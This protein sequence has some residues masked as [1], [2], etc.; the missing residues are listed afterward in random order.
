[1]QL[2]SFSSP[3]PHPRMHVSEDSQEPTNFLIKLRLARSVTC[4]FS[5]H[6]ESQW[7]TT[8]FVFPIFVYF[9]YHELCNAVRYAFFVRD[10]DP[11]PL[12]KNNIFIWTTWRPTKETWLLV[13]RFFQTTIRP[14]PIPKNS[15]SKTFSTALISFF[16]KQTFRL[17]KKL[18]PDW[19][20]YRKLPSSSRWLNHFCRV[21]APSLT[22]EIPKSLADEIFSARFFDHL[23]IRTSFRCSTSSKPFL[24]LQKHRGS[25]PV[26]V[27]DLIYLLMQIRSY[28]QLYTP[29]IT[30]HIHTFSIFQN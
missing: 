17:F 1:M 10:S 26:L 3:N 2:E 7:R 12:R 5:D 4:L 8:R 24:A 19:I 16:W 28:V 14:H 22:L 21:N 9:V 23:P 25:F 27:P 15:A 11:F 29:P 13:F 20:C 18:K 6:H 30:F